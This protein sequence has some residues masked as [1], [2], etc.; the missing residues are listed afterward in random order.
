[1]KL[2]NRELQN[3]LR[4]HHVEEKVPRGWSPAAS[5]RF[6]RYAGSVSLLTRADRIS[7]V[8]GME[9]KIIRPGILLRPYS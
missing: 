8:S 5:R 6:G 7:S 1:M 3:T 2:G 4:V 9:T